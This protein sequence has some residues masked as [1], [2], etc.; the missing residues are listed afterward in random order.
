MAPRFGRL[1][2]VSRRRRSWRNRNSTADARTSFNS[3]SG[4]G[5]WVTQ[6]VTMVVAPVVSLRPDP[7]TH[8]TKPTGV[9]RLHSINAACLLHKYC[10]GASHLR[11]LLRRNGRRAHHQNQCGACQGALKRTKSGIPL[12]LDPRWMPTNSP[13]PSSTALSAEPGSRRSCICVLVEFGHCPRSRLSRMHVPCQFSG[14]GFG[15]INPDYSEKSRF[16]TICETLHL[17]QIRQILAHLEQG[18]RV[19]QDNELV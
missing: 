17:P 16:P 1:C 12:C 13:P 6:W 9:I 10:R 4:S 2:S 5:H 8:L 3:P 15:P 18:V 19:H 7:D 14:T 11:Y